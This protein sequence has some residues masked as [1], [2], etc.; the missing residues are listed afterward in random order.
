MS[1][2]VGG[3]MDGWMDRWINGW[4]DRWVGGWIMDKRMGKG[5]NVWIDGC[6][7]SAKCTN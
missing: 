1:G 4:M 2:W 5:R 3:W 6:P 7:H